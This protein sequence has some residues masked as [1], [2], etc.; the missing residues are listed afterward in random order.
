MAQLR[1]NEKTLMVVVK[2]GI[3]FLLLLNIS[4]CASSNYKK[5]AKLDTI[6]AYEDFISKHE[7]STEFVLNAQKRIKELKWE[8]VQRKHTIEAYEEFV[9]LYPEDTVFSSEARKNID[10]LQ[11]QKAK[12]LNT[13]PAYQ[14]Y[15]TLF[16]NETGRHLTEA[17]EAIKGLEWA[18]VK[19]THTVQA[20]K[21]FIK[22]YPHDDSFISEAKVQIENLEYE[23]ITHTNTIQ[24]YERY[25]HQYG[26]LGLHSQDAKEQIKLLTW[27]TTAQQNT[28]GA[29]Q[30]FLE[31]Y[32]NDFTL[33]SEAK[34]RI[35]DLSFIT[36]QKVDTIDSY[37]EY[38]K[39]YGS[40]GRHYQQA[41]NRLQEFEWNEAK[42]THTIESYVQFLA[43]YSADSELRA[44]AK[45]ALI[46]LLY[47]TKRRKTSKLSPD[48]ELYNNIAFWSETL[49]DNPSSVYEI[50]AQLDTFYKSMFSTNGIALL[51]S[52]EV[53]CRQLV[54]SE[55]NIKFLQ[56]YSQYPDQKLLKNMLE[57]GAKGLEIV[58]GLD[59]LTLGKMVEGDDYAGGGIAGMLIA[60]F[61]SIEEAN[62]RKEYAQNA[63]RQ[64]QYS[65]QLLISE[66]YATLETYRQNIAQKHNIDQENFYEIGDFKPFSGTK[67]ASVFYR[68]MGS[69]LPAM[70]IIALNE[71]LARDAKN[72]LSE[73]KWEEF[74]M[75]TLFQWPSCVSK[76][77]SS[78]SDTLTNLSYIALKK[79]EYQ[80]GENFASK[81]IKSNR[82]NVTAWNNRAIM[83]LRQGKTT[84]A[85]SDIEKAITLS[86]NYSW[87]W[88]SK[89]RILAKGFDRKNAAVNALDKA[90]S[91]GFSDI[92][93]LKTDN[94]LAS[95]RGFYRFEETVKVKT[96][97]S[98]EWGVFN[99]DIRLKNM[100]AFPL[101]NVTLYIHIE[102]GT[103]YWERTL[104]TASIKSGE[105]KE[106]VNAV[107]IPGGSFTK[108]TYNVSCDQCE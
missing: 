45:N 14:E 10:D 29:Y 12:E 76:Q 41:Q 39:S 83:R 92:R 13:I 100:S 46:N 94:D 79:G 73:S 30:A 8:D 90:I 26:E 24:A 22:K 104:T 66:Y 52:F 96:T 69:R 85:L 103:R 95:L 7:N 18:N 23:D 36:A 75:S 72:Y 4:G 61:N 71:K 65:Q 55:L 81:A 88:F 50:Q 99:D 101:S 15:L 77:H 16:E 9:N 48:Q 59:Q 31:K 89:A 68:F 25:L 62:R 58:K 102:K 6:E 70:N 43:K 67:S 11:F 42:K 3:C 107:S 105:Q 21:D 27:E 34:N 17:H 74:E 80:N 40:N 19:D 87:L 108:F 28:I 47:Q 106:W 91:L 2:I 53:L 57:G 60:L 37:R 49:A 97:C 35:D 5:A 20:Y 51:N 54:A 86:P 33:S 56:E 84:A 38:L 44:Y 93:L 63:I 64:E 98:I 82:T 32:S 78:Y 1:L